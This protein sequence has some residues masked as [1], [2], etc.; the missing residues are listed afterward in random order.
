[1]DSRFNYLKIDE[2]CLLRHSVCV[3]VMGTGVQG[4]IIVWTFLAN[5]PNEKVS[6]STIKIKTKLKRSVNVIPRIR[7]KGTNDL[8]VCIRVN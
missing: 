4:D 8:F 3:N 6:P 7:K 1:M 5:T 2:F